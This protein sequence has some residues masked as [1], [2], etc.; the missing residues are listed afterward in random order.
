MSI[1][2]SRAIVEYGLLVPMCV[3]AWTGAIWFIVFVVK[4]AR[5]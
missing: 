5:K 2:V 3:A 1:E 4:E